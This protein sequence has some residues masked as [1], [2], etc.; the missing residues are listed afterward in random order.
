[1]EILHLHRFVCQIVM[2]TVRFSIISS[3]LTLFTLYKSFLTSASWWWVT[4]WYWISCLQNVL[5]SGDLAS[6]STLSSLTDVKGPLCCLHFLRR[7]STKSAALGWKKRKIVLLWAIQLF[8]YKLSHL[9]VFWVSV[10]DVSFEFKSHQY[11]HAFGVDL[12]TLLLVPLK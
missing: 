5:K 11:P 2:F 7:W 9:V 6:M 1:M 4:R 8:P 10:N 3:K 12:T